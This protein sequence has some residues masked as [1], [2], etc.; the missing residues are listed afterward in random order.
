MDKTT[1]KLVLSAYRSGTH[2]KEDPFFTEALVAVEQDPE[3]A[4]WFEGEQRF[5][6]WM[7]D[8]LKR[9]RLHLAWRS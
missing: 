7:V 8:T 9:A 5:D 3:L 2:D 4:A 1:I 6:A